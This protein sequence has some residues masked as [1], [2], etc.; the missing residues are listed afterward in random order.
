MAFKVEES[1]VIDRPP[2]EVWQYVV[3]HNE[4]RRPDIVQV[5]KLTDGPVGSGTRYE[6]TARQMGREMTTV[7]EVQRFEPPRYISWTQV[8]RNGPAYTV[9]GCY[10]LESL[11]GKTRFTLVGNY[12]APG[13][14]QLMVPFIRRKIENDIFPRFVRQLK[15]I[16]ESEQ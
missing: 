15:D 8:G 14:W 4:W 7:N 6:N 5:R 3:E 10:Q 2:E 16:L 12:E 11:D 13:L 1:I 9:E